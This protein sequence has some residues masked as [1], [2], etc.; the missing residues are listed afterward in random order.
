MSVPTGNYFR[1]LSVLK[2]VK[3]VTP[4]SAKTACHIPPIPAT[5]NN[6]IN[7]FTLIAKIRFCFITPHVFL[8]IFIASNILEILSVISM[9]H[10]RITHSMNYKPFD[11]V[12]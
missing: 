11:L 9:E 1:I 8:E 6:N 10:R 4:T 5:L 3:I 2:I 7:T 12:I